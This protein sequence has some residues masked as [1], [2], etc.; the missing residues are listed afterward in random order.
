MP[1]VKFV[2]C[3]V[4][5]SRL[6]INVFD[7]VTG[8]PVTEEKS[9]WNGSKYNDVKEITYMKGDEIV[10]PYEVMERLGNSVEVVMTPVITKPMEVAA[11]VPPSGG[12]KEKSDEKTVAE[13][14]PKEPITT[15]P[16]PKRK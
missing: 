1:G 13:I 14:I 9:E 6:R 5:M 11:P 3:K 8:E 10:I 7:N 4:L 2:K 12:I 16:G 15:R